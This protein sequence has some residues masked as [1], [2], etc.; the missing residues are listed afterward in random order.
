M[1][2]RL[3]P[4]RH[5]ASALFA[6]I[7]QDFLAV[8]YHSLV[9]GAVPAELRVTAW[10]PDGVIMALE[11][12][13]R[14]LFGV[15]F[16]PES[17]STRHGRAL[18][19]NFRDLTPRRRPAARPAG[20]PARRRTGTAEREH[21]A[22]PPAPGGVVRAR[23]RLRRAVRRPRPRG[24][25]RQLARRG[26]R[27]ALLL[28]RR[29]GRAAGPG[30]PLRR[31]RADGR[32]RARVRPRGARRE[33]VRPL[34]PR[35]RAPARRRAR[36]AV[37]LRRRVR[38]LLRLRAEGRVRRPPAHASPLPDAAPAPVRPGDRLRPPGAPG[39]SARADRRRRPR[40]RRRLARRDRAAAARARPRAA[41]AAAGAR[42]A[43]QP[44]VRAPRLGGGVPGEHRRLPAG[45]LRGRELRDLP[46]DGAA[47]RGD[48]RPGVRVPGAARPQPRPVRRAPAAG[49]AVRAQLLPRA[50][51][52]RR[53]RAHRRVAADEGHGGA[54]G[55]AVRRTP[56]A[57]P[58]CG[59]TRR[60]APRTS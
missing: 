7:P 11:H 44:A 10:T 56:A 46:D 23:G 53:P 15:Q 42:R 17:V 5:D 14:P 12:R 16:H 34:P 26:G 8:R 20:A 36:A 13:A 54:A 52:A 55:G 40:G 33:R 35:A 24:L 41:A 47:E 32:G 27:R 38:G 28:H 19:E 57:R 43:R 29:A 49:R 9:V 58:S 48:A 37:R 45:D 31:R 1:H 60:P 51:P 50:V 22:A 3:S 6:G 2:G 39:P 25:A 59:G 30:R 21:R 18:L 4:I